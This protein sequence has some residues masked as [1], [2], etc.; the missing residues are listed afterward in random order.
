MSND[1]NDFLLGG[2]TPSAKFPAIGTT[3][4]GTITEPP[5][6]VDDRDLDGN[7]RVWDNGDAKKVLLVTV[8]T[9]ERD[10][11][12]AGD[13][14]HR[15]LYVKGSKNPESK[16]MTAA[17]AQ[18]VRS[19]KA[20]GLEVG[21]TLTVTY[22]ADGKQER[23][24]YNAPKQYE[25]TY[26][27]PSVQASAEFL[28]ATEAPAAAPAPAAPAANPAETAKQLIAAG[29][30]VADTAKTVGLPEAV[31]QAIANTVAA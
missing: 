22:V 27:P 8:A 5:K 18:A 12:I 9:A 4:T 29:V 6:V 15:R 31:V 17:L 11:E 26:V 19:A 30:S 13:D 14:G 2:G 25:A 3:I 23:R 7:V 10:P 20:N 21:G 1:A 24:G 28:G 16:S